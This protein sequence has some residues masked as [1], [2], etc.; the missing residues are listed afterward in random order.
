MV[1]LYTYLEMFLDDLSKQINLSEFENY[2][3]K[4]HQTI[5]K[6]LTKLVNSNIL[7]ETKKN[8]FLFYKLNLEYK[9]TKEY[10]IICEKERLINFLKKEILFSRLYG[11]L[12]DFFITS[13][14]LVFG[15]S[16]KN[17][18]YNDIDLLILSKDNNI[19]K[20]IKKFQEIY[21]IKIHLILTNEKELNKT[22]LKELKNNHIIFNNHDYFFDL[23]Y[24]F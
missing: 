18:D 24:C 17:K 7:I 4:P 14:C 3:K 1:N 21:S 20:V 6:H 5:K 9:L 15:S 22:F 13:N 2:F 10:L 8:K 16:V 11:L 19:K 23:L 12:S